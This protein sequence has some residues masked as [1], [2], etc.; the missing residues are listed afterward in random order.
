[1]TAAV[2]WAGP[3]AGVARLMVPVALKVLAEAAT[4]CPPTTPTTPAGVPGVTPQLS[5]GQEAA[6]RWWVGVLTAGLHYAG[7]A[8]VPHR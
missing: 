6:F 7:A 2:V 5:S 1:M 8:V 3:E 4:I